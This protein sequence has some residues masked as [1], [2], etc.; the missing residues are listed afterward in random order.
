MT[1]IDNGGTAYPI[2][3]RGGNGL[4]LTDIGMTLLDHF[5][6]LAMQGW[7]AS[8]GPDARHPSDLGSD[9]M[10]LSAKQSYALARIMIAEKRRLEEDRSE[11]RTD[12]CSW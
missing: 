8:Y 6:G 9:A 1:T 7:L 5:A 4:E 10:I 12:E 3:E 2:L 11:A